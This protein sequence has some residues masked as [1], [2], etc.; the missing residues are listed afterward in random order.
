MFSANAPFQSPYTITLPVD[1]H[2]VKLEIV[3][4]STVTL[5]NEASL[6]K[7]PS[8]LPA[9]S[10]FPYDIPPCHIPSRFDEPLHLCCLS[11][12]VHV[13]FPTNIHNTDDAISA[14][15]PTSKIN[16]NRDPDPPLPSATVSSSAAEAPVPATTADNPDAPSNINLTAAN[17]SDV[18]SVQTC[19]HCD[20]TFTSHI[21]LVGHLRIHRTEAGEP[22]PGVTT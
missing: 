21:G 10:T 15:C 3:T 4:G 2:P 19:P 20:R 11:Y 9:S 12:S 6:Q 16:H 13:L 17:T 1:C 5:I 22:V 14:S 8:F 7:L 18:D